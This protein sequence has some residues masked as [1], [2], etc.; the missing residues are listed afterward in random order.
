MTQNS[1]Q[2]ITVTNVIKQFGRPEYEQWFKAR[3]HQRPLDAQK[4]VAAFRRWDQE[5]GAQKAK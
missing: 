1:S 2:I 3:P 4:M 5:I